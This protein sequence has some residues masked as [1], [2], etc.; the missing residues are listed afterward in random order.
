[1]PIFLYICFLEKLKLSKTIKF[2][3]VIRLGVCEVYIN[4]SNILWSFVVG[5]PRTPLGKSG[6]SDFSKSIGSGMPAQSAE[7]MIIYPVSLPE[8]SSLLF[9]WFPGSSL[10]SQLNFSISYQ[11]M[12]V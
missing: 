2:P 5:L 7:T 1:V 6:A 9:S 11:E 10:K 3:N 12:H 8:N 4:P